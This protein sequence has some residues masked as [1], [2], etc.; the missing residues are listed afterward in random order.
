[1][2]KRKSSAKAAPKQKLAP[3]C[4]R[5]PPPCPLPANKLATAFKCLFCHHDKAVS[6]KM[7]VLEIIL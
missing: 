6:V 2:G 4:E 5:A 3:L 1:M 7:S